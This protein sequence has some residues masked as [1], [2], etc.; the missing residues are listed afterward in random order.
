MPPATTISLKDTF[1][2]NNERNFLCSLHVPTPRTYDLT[3]KKE[4]ILINARKTSGDREYAI[5]KIRTR[6]RD[7]LPL[8]NDSLW[9]RVN[10]GGKRADAEK[11]RVLLCKE[12]KPTRGW[13]N[14]SLVLLLRVNVMPWEYFTYLKEL[15]EHV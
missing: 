15:R 7:G 2:I 6:S 8:N 9:I 4:Q 5:A 3:D 11:F 13:K 10:K 12:E 14:A 1:L